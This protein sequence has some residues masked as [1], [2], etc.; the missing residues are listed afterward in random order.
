MRKLNHDDIP[1]LIKHANNKKIS[2]RILNMPHPYSEPQAAFRIAYVN[3]GFNKKSRFVF[4]ILLNTNQEFIGEISLHLEPNDCAQLGYW[5]GETHWNNGYITE[6]IE[7]ILEFGFNKLDLKQIH[8]TCKR[9]N[10][11]SITALK[12]NA[13]AASNVNNPVLN[14]IILKNEFEQATSKTY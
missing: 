9:D 2:D 1:S 14:F 10:I 7:T 5:I 13:F 12:K 3:E 6:A 4:S 11:G 8:A